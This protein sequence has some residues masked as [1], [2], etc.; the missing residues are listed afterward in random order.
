M[1]TPSMAVNTTI[2]RIR[3]S[4]LTR[5]VTQVQ[6]VHPH[7]RIPKTTVAWNRPVHVRSCTTRD[8][9]WVIAKTN[10]KSKKSS[11]VVADFSLSVKDDSSVTSLSCEGRQRYSRY[12]VPSFSVT[13]LRR[14][15]R[16]SVKALSAMPRPGILA[17][18]PCGPRVIL[19]DV[20]SYF[21]PCH[22]QTRQPSRSML[23]LAKSA[24]K[25]RHRRDTANR[26]SPLLPT[27]K[28]PTATTVPDGRSESGPT[29]FSAMSL[30]GVVTF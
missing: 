19:P 29:F 18:I 11:S 4:R 20:T 1:N 25:C 2:F 30:Q 23:P 16:T 10:T 21:A 14:S 9:T 28:P 17:K 3:G 27:A 15:G 26:S 8:T 22:G 13:R 24:F 5:F 6:L 7:H 12:T